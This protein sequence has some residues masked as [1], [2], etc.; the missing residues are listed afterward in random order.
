M[1]ERE[2][3]ITKEATCAH[4]FYCQSSAPSGQP[5]CSRDS[6][7]PRPP[8][9]SSGRMPLAAW[10]TT[11]LVQGRLPL[12]QSY[13]ADACLAFMLPSLMPVAAPALQ[14]EATHLGRLGEDLMDPWKT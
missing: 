13:R 5:G 1:V 14:A 6:L 9:G 7:V 12:C 11:E 2:T 4:G 3:V 8:T 10:P